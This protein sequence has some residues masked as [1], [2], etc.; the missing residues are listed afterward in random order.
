MFPASSPYVT[1]VGGTSGG[2]GGDLSQQIACSSSEGQNITTGGGFSNYY[3]KP[4]F[5]V[6]AIS[7]YFSQISPAQS[8]YAQYNPKFRGY[9]D[10]SLIAADYLVVIGGEYYLLSGTG[11]AASVFAGMVSLVNA[12]RFSLGHPPLGWI[13]P[14]IYYNNGEFA[15][16]VTVGTNNCLSTD[17]C[18]DIGFTAAVGWVSI[19]ILMMNSSFAYFQVIYVIGSSNWLWNS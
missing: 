12:A 8:S 4:E 9:P 18:C 17:S 19:T 7:D 16:D 3:L 6:N 13:N 2:T 10:V 15:S 1:V 11:A 14:G 5:Q